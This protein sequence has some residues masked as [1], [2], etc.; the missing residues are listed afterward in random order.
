MHQRSFYSWVHNIVDNS[1][2]LFLKKNQN[3]V[4]AGK[5]DTPRLVAVLQATV[6]CVWLSNFDVQLD[7]AAVMWSFVFY[8]VYVFVLV[9]FDDHRITVSG[10]AVVILVW[11]VHRLFLIKSIPAQRE[12]GAVTRVKVD[13]QWSWWS[14]LYLTTTKNTPK[15]HRKI[16]IPFVT[17][18]NRCICLKAAHFVSLRKR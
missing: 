2:A 13:T 7:S 1:A 18:Q 17:P 6:P 12:A 9:K 16:L 15:K 3:T 8:T 4:I 10:P 5:G 14:H 11:T